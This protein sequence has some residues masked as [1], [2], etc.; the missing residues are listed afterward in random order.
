MLFKLLV[1]LLGL[2]FGLLNQIVV[3]FSLDM[4]IGILYFKKSLN[5]EV[6]KNIIKNWQKFQDRQFS[7]DDIF[8][9]NM[10]YSY[11]DIF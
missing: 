9:L 11:A 1:Q 6:T 4:L 3:F 8:F 7:S 10:Y 5:N 2:P